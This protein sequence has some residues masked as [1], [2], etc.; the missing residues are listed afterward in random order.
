LIMKN[1]LTLV[2]AL[3]REEPEDR[4][5]AVTFCGGTEAITFCDDAINDVSGA[6][7]QMKMELGIA[8]VVVD[9]ARRRD[10][11]DLTLTPRAMAVLAG[12]LIART[13]RTIVDLQL[14]LEDRSV[15]IPMA[16][17]YPLL[18]RLVGIGLVA[19]KDEQGPKG[20]PKAFYIITHTGRRAVSLGHAVA[21]SLGQEGAEANV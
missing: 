19:R 6:G 14:E 2:K 21:K 15:F 9:M 16:S 4:A 13:W 8:A 20:R 5:E 17:L 11:P 18:D 10:A 3:G 12:L 7:R 1:A